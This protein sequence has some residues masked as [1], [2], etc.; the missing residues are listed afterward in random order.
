MTRVKRSCN[1]DTVINKTDM[2]KEEMLRASWEYWE[3]RGLENPEKREHNK[4]KSLK[5]KPKEFEE[6][7]TKN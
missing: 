4:I 7:I 6:W 5:P 2:S 3:R 1:A